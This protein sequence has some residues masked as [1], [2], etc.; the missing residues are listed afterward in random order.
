MNKKDLNY[1]VAKALG[2]IDEKFYSEVASLPKTKKIS[3][4]LLILVAM[5]GVLTAS[6]SVTSLY[7]KVQSQFSQ[8]YGDSPQELQVIQEIARPVQGSAT[9]HGLTLSVDGIMGDGISAEI[10]YSIQHEDGSPVFLE[11]LPED[12][13]PEDMEQ[14]SDGQ[15]TWYHWGFQE[16]EVLDDYGSPCLTGTQ[17]DRFALGTLYGELEYIMEDHQFLGFVEI[18]KGDKLPLGQT[19][20]ALFSQFGYW[21]TKMTYENGILL[22]WERDF[23]P[24]L[25]G[26]WQVDYFFAYGDTQ[27]I[28]LE[29]Q[30]LLHDDI[31]VQLTK[32]EITAL[33]Y[34]LLLE[35]PNF[36]E[37]KSYHGLSEEEV[38]LL[39]KKLGEQAQQQFQFLESFPFYFT[40]KDG[41]VEQ[42]SAMMSSGYSDSV[43]QQHKTFYSFPEILLLDEIASVT[44]GNYTLEI[45]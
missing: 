40:M 23:V 25:A 41:R 14:V 3:K 39:N 15:Y 26:N 31:V 13:V 8:R 4:T 2:E 42:H 7:E 43:T 22:E 44:I 35:Y 30:E 33:S 10:I 20:T 28:L 9:S 24:V 11:P 27:S 29:N 45:P 17:V 5:I 21:Q 12:H 38:E 19:V 34:E 37:H 32:L 1:A 16:L 36:E 18:L 6:G